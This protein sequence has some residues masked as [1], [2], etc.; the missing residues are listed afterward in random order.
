MQQTSVGAKSSPSY[1]LMSLSVL[2]GARVLTSSVLLSLAE[3]NDANTAVN[4]A[5]QKLQ[6]VENELSTVKPLAA[7]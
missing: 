4:A 1:W 2:V 6:Q 7:K 3:L 5:R